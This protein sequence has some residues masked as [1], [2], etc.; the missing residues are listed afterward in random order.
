[1]LVVNDPDASTTEGEWQEAIDEVAA[2]LGVREDHL[3]D[4]A[5]AFIATR[6]ARAAFDARVERVGLD[7]S[8]APD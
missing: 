7:R 8:F 2:R 1:M 6:A 5:Y 3:P 4:A